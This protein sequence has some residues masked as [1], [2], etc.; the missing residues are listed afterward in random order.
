MNY[1]KFNTDSIYQFLDESDTYD[2]IDYLK[3]PNN[4]RSF[5]QGLSEII[6]KKGYA[7]ESSSINELTK[8]LHTKL[9]TIGAKISYNTVEAWF[10][11]EHRPKIE[12]GYRKQIYEICFAL[13]LSYDETLWFFHHVYYDRAFNCHTIDE[14]VFYFCFKNDLTYKKALSLIKEI[15]DAPSENITPSMEANYTQFVQKNLDEFQSSEELISFLVNN[16]ENFN[17]WN[18]SAYKKLTILV[19]ELLPTECGKKE[20]ENIKRTIKRKNT[21]YGI[22]PKL[23]DQKEWGLVMQEFFFEFIDESSLEYIEGKNICS[24]N[25]LLDRIL[26]KDITNLNKNSKSNIEIPYIVKNNFPTR[27]TLSDV[28]SEEKT[29]HSKSYDAIRKVIILL[30]FYRFWC[31]IKIQNKT[32]ISLDEPL[33]DVFIAE[34]NDLLYQCGYEKIYAGNPYDWLFLC[35]SQSDEPLLYFRQCISDLLLDD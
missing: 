17:S 23:N 12:A 2:A 19:K 13:N 18:R 25:F 10:K 5:N 6:K 1:T 14:A 20:I 16:K 4:F 28:L 26:N 30:Y 33:S 29:L 31:E 15:T 32:N 24:K 21:V 7:S 3:N 11:G 8:S 35:S 27:K 22:I 9:E 34:I